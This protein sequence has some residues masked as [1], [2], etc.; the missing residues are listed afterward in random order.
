[1]PTPVDQDALQCWKTPAAVPPPTLLRLVTVQLSCKGTLH[2]L[3]VHRGE[4]AQTTT[5]SPRR[6]KSPSL[7]ASSN[8]RSCTAWMTAAPNSWPTSTWDQVEKDTTSEGKVETDQD[9]GAWV[10]T[11]VVSRTMPMAGEKG[12]SR[13]RMLSPTQTQPACTRILSRDGARRGHD[14]EALIV[15]E[16]AGTGPPA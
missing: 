3:P 6:R 1:M 11:V 16:L 7:H 5:S 12:L 4:T 9:T 8:T 2:A 14:A 15:V 13:T 10:T